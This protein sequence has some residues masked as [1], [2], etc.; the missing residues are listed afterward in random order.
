MTVS[1]VRLKD[2]PLGRQDHDKLWQRDAKSV[3]TFRVGFVCIL[4]A[5]WLAKAQKNI[6]DAND[7]LDDPIA[8]LDQSDPIARPPRSDK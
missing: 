6:D 8:R 4:L 2:I 1:A 3:V 7:P 5:A